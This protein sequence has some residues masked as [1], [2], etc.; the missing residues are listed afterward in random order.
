[1]QDRMLDAADILI[2]RQ[3]IIDR[4]RDRPALAQGIGEAGEIPGGIH[5]CVER[6]GFPPRR[7]AASRTIDFG[8]CRMGDRSGLPWTLNSRSS[9]NLTGNSLS[10]TG[11]TPHWP[12][13]II[14]IGQPQA[15]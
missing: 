12:Q 1:M 15:R 5:E 14:G 6:V 10:G 3:P 11:T 13:W 9:G 8:K 2:D 7:A 4:G